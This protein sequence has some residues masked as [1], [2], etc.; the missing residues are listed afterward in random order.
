MTEGQREELVEELEYYGLLDRI[1]PYHAQDRVGQALLRRARV[2]GT[3][4]ALELAV[5]Q[6]IGL[7]FET[8]STKPFLTAEYQ[9]LRWMITDRVVNESPVWSEVDGKLFLFRNARGMMTISSS[10]SKRTPIG[11]IFNTNW[12]P[13]AGVTAPIEL[14]SDRWVSCECATLAPQFASAHQFVIAN[15]LEVKE[16]VRVPE[17]RI[18]TLHGLDN[19]EPSMAA[20]LR[21]LAALT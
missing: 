7:V 14:L 20:A 13:I 21:Q 12:G 15:T 8:N 3:R 6:A 2:D 5:A 4:R 1:L 16:H 10:C 11:T 9:D 19:S 17:L 18:T